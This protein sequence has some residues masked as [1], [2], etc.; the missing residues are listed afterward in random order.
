M[1]KLNTKTVPS[2]SFI[3]T[4]T[5]SRRGNTL[6]PKQQLFV[7]EYLVDRNAKQA[8]LR[9]GFSEKTASSYS[10]TLL[11]R[12]EI[13]AALE[14]ARS[15]RDQCT[16]IDQDYV[17]NRLMEIVER[18]LGHDPRRLPESPWKTEKPRHGPAFSE[19][20]R[21]PRCKA[22]EITPTHSLRALLLLTRY[23]GGFDLKGKDAQDITVIVDTGVPGPPGSQS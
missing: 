22:L 5:F 1:E 23:T 10:Y 21:C 15:S 4:Q 20:L 11:R 16:G 2:R 19:I 8:A 17:V 13:Q 3:E 7:E 14:Q 6:T 12:P 9:A 18:G